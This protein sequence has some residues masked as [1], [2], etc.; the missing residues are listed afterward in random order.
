MVVREANHSGV[1]SSAL[2]DEF[3]ELPMHLMSYGID[4]HWPDDVVESKYTS[5]RKRPSFRCPND[6]LRLYRLI[7]EIS[8]S[9]DT[10]ADAMLRDDHSFAQELPQIKHF[11]HPLLFE[12]SACIH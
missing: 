2:P 3:D 8:D 10:G 5:V 11:P 9:T 4:R 1:G 7:R 12:R 6:L